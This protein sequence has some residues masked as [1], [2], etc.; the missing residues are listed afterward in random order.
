[1]NHPAARDTKAF[2]KKY[3]IL[4]TISMPRSILLRPVIRNK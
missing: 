1:M 2:I 4:L 3:K